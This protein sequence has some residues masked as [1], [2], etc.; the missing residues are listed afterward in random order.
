MVLIDLKL[1]LSSPQRRYLP[2][3][4]GCWT[5]RFS[6]IV[7]FAGQSGALEVV[8]GEEPSQRTRRWRHGPL[9]TLLRTLS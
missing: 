3:A 9:G 8:Q 5:A 2:S 1:I 6:D 4:T 7:A